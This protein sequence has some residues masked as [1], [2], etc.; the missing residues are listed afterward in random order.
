MTSSAGDEVCAGQDGADLQ[1]QIE[2]KLMAE[3]EFA[4]PDEQ[5]SFLESQVPRIAREIV[6]LLASQ[7]VSV[8]EACA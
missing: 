1:V 4:K 2:A 7:C 5:L 6:F 8:S 3:I